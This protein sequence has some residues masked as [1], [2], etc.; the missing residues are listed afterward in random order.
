MKI[1]PC[2]EKWNEGE[3]DWSFVKDPKSEIEAWENR[4]GLQLPS[5]YKSFMATFNGGCVYPR[6]FKHTIPSTVVPNEA[7]ESFVDTIYDWKTV[8][9]H[10]SGATYDRESVPPN[11][12]IFAC[13]PGSIELLMALKDEQCG[14]I[15]AWPHFNSRWN[16]DPNTRIYLLAKTFTEFLRSLF[17]DERKS[18]YDGWHIPAYDKLAKNFDL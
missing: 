6:L 14:N 2:L 12:I 18:D 7:G 1:A 13:T 17:D 5:D 16:T 4:E 11:H 9:A 10:W 8:E 15:F 3:R